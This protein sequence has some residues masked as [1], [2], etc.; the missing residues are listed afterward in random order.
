MRI[1]A[2]FALPAVTVAALAVTAD[3]VAQNQTP[4]FRD[5]LRVSG[6]DVKGSSS[7]H[8][9][10]FSGPFA[11]PGVTLPAG[12]YVFQ[13]AG[14]GILRVLSKDERQVYAAMHTTETWR[15]RSTSE[16]SVIWEKNVAGAPPRLKEWFASGRNI[17]QEL[18]YPALEAP[19]QLAAR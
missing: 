17:G 18:A 4:R 14:G 16:Y 3:A 10:T 6:A 11:L 8:F 13:K 15:V 12:T 7:D 5:D 1:F 2:R 9:M 19:R